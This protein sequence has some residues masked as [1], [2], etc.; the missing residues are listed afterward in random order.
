MSVIIFGR[1]SY[2]RVHEHA[3]EYADTQ[4]FHLNFVPLLPMQSHWITQQIGEE[5][6]GFPIR[7]HLPSVAAAYL[8]IW[9]P[10]GAMA[11]FMASGSI[12]AVAA[13][14]ALVAASAWSWTWRSRRGARTL[15]RSDFD[16]VALGSRC[17]PAWMTA[18]MRQSLKR[19]LD[20]ELARRTDPRSPEDVARFGATDAAEALLAY[21]LLRLGAHDH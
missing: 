14:L 10:V 6:A 11:I 9:G 2:G 16:R 5:R 4:F 15:Q 7:L 19:E 12:P 21:G 1:R 17:D 20:A 8:R 13:S 3:G 18:A